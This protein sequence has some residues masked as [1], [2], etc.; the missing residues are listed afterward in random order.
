MIYPLQSYYGIA[1]HSNQGDMAGM[2]K[3]V[4]NIFFTWPRQKKT[5]T[6]GLV[7]LKIQIGGV[8]CNEIKL[9]VLAILFMVLVHHIQ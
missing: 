4:C 6:T 1:I 2:Q 9:M 8:A 3:R 7:A 5:T